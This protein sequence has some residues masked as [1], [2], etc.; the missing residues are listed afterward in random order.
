MGRTISIH[1][2]RG[3][4][5]KT[6][7]TANLAALAVQAGRRVG[8]VDT[9]IQSP[10]LHVPFGWSS[11]PAGP[12]LNDY[13]WG[14]C[15][16]EEAAYPVAEAEVGPGLFLVPGSL[17]TGAITKVLRE[18]FDVGR[19]NDGFRRLKSALALDALFIDTHPGLNPETLLSVAIS[20][21]VVVVLRPD[22]QDYQGT[23][24]TIDVARRLEVPELAIVVNKVPDGT[25]LAALKR[26]VEAAYGCPVLAVLPHS[27][28]LMRLSSAELFGVRYP[29]DPLTSELRGVALHVV[30]AMTGAPSTTT[31]PVGPT[32]PRT[33]TP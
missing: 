10:G 13:L 3:G 15:A 28:A 23:S 14:K 6:N 25:D 12:T 24:V 33:A 5:G 7:L 11:T 19:L 9:D 16:I 17:N 21:C 8:V 30:G 32:P 1:S 26:D 31:S 4:T 2:Y 29:D 22:Q 18:G 20:D 27:D